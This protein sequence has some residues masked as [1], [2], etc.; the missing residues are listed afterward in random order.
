MNGTST[1][2]PR[3][4]AESAPPQGTGCEQPPLPLSW[5]EPIPYALTVR[6]R[7]AVAPTSLPDLSVVPAE[8]APTDPFD[9]RP[10]RARALR[11]SGLA[12]S[13]VAAALD[14][15]E[16]VAAAWCSAVNVPARR[17]APRGARPGPGTS[18]VAVLPIHGEE[19]AAVRRSAAETLAADLAE[20]TA[21][22]AAAAAIVAAVAQLSPYAMTV[23]TSDP[24]VASCVI[25]V[26]RGS[27]DV[28]SDRLRVS[29]HAGPAVA[30]D[31]A[32]QRWSRLLDVPA[33]TV[34]HAPW[35]TAPHPHGV[36]VT[37]RAA[38]PRAA[39][40]VAGWRETLGRHPAAGNVP[41]GHRT[42][43]PQTVEV[44]HADDTSPTARDHPLSGRPAQP[45]RAI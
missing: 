37:V 12:V 19:H 15:S 39:A 41:A 20:A 40:T 31:V 28:P 26:L 45:E 2:S 17:R 10:A 7:R 34:T 38:D 44:I 30:R 18:D 43:E 22:R 33:R 35:P 8:Q 1:A 9:P 29:V 14:V 4:A 23:T 16:D 42:E 13:D 3:T 32:T 5:D 27:L 21:G 24:V 36:R 25:R 11:R 6:A